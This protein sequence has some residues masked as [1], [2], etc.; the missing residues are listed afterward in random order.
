MATLNYGLG[1]RDM[2]FAAR[3][4]LCKSGFSAGI[5]GHW[6]AFV[7]WAKP[8]GINKMEKIDKALVVR[9]GKYLETLVAKGDIKPANA[10][11]YISAVNMVMYKATSHRWESI[12][13]PQ[14]LIYCCGCS[15]EVAARLTYG[16]EVYPHRADLQ[17]QPF[18]RCDACGNFVGCHYKTK[19]CTTPMGC[20][21]TLEIKNERKRIHVLLDSIWKSGRIGRM[22]LYQAISNEVGWE[23]HTGQIRSVSDAHKVYSILLRYT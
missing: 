18:W 16:I 2:K 15:I 12:S 9:Y 14:Q 8:Q 23:Y 1:S 10:Q 4:L 6:N 3:R 20:I 22:K 19:A 13:Q 17:E 21:P 7:D 5:A 11:V